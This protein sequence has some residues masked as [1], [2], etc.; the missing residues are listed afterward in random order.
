[1]ASHFLLSAK[2]RTLSL[3]Q[4]ARLSDDQAFATFRALR[5]HATGGDPVCPA[6]GC[7]AAYEFKTR[8]LF[9]CKGC[10]KQFSVTS[11]TTFHGRKLPM[12]D[13]LMAITIFANAAKGI[14]ALQLGRDL[15][16]SYKTA[17]V[18]AHKLRESMA[19]DQAKYQP[20]GHVE[21]DGAY[22]G[23]HRKPSAHQP[24]GAYANRFATSSASARTSS[25]DALLGSL[26]TTPRPCAMLVTKA[27]RLPS[28]Q[29]SASAPSSVRAPR[30]SSIERPRGGTR[31]RTIATLRRSLTA[32]LDRGLAGPDVERARLARHQ[33]QVGAADRGL[34]VDLG[35]RRGVDDDQLGL[36]LEPVELDAQPPAADH[37][38]AQL[39]RI[40]LA[41]LAQP[42]PA[43]EAALRVDVDQR[44]LAAQRAQRGR[45]L[46]HQR[47]LAGAALL[48]C[49]RDHRRGHRPSSCVPGRSIAARPVDHVQQRPAGPQAAQVLDHALGRD[50]RAR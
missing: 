1:M 16:V 31:L 27:C 9:K 37:R 40:A 34:G 49:H 36:A 38:E 8:R 32:M 45:E 7:V 14:S 48:L 43:G 4:V 24:D 23:G 30:A 10:G 46:D 28:W 21:I 33:D 18:L 11:G 6:C 29:A 15:D 13:Y 17:F 41:V 25:A 39:G 20:Q 19:A 42:H 12:R 3:V 5:W 22:L 50:L 35:V 2:A 44:H 47:G 26:S